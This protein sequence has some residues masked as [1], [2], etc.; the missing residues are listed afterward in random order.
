MCCAGLCAARDAGHLHTD[1]TDD[2]TVPRGRQGRTV[3]AWTYLTPA[4]VAAIET[5]AAIPDPERA[6]YTVAIYTGLRAGELWALRWED[7]VLG[8][9]TP[10]I[11]VRASHDGPTKSGKVRRVPLLDPA[12]AA[13]ARLPGPREGRVFPGLGGG[14]RLRGDDAR[15]A[16]AMR[17]GGAI[18]GYRARAG[19]TRR[20]RFHDL[21]HTCASHLVM[22]TWAPALS[23][24]EVAQWLGHSSVSVTQRY[25]HLCPDRLA[26]RVGRG[27]GG[28]GTDGDG[29]ECGGGRGPFEGGQTAHAL[30]ASLTKTP[31]NQARPAR[32]ERATR[33]LEGPANAKAQQGLARGRGRCVD[34]AVA[35]LTLAARGESLP[36][37]RA[38]DLARAAISEGLCGPRALA[39][40]DAQDSPA[41]A[42][43]AVD[44]AV[45]VLGAAGAQTRTA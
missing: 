4:E 15:W 12:L 16:P 23:L 17:A 33:G 18:N 35:I 5:C 21:R 42:R 11:T 1:P 40:I 36:R 10:E 24:L 9:P 14:A 39:V 32:L 27:S 13:L 25:A 3:E 20:V 26:A 45:A 44:L 19:I 30:T 31:G 2:V 34:D 38:V 43:A 8:G 22:G 37:G 41:L 7:V 6:I 28:G 29:G